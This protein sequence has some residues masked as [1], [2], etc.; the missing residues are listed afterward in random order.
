MIPVRLQYFLEYVWNDWKCDKIWTLGP[1]IYQQNASRNSRRKDG[2]LLEA[3]FSYPRIWNSAK[4]GRFFA[5]NVLFECMLKKTLEVDKMKFR[6]YTNEIVV[7]WNYA[8]LKCC[9]SCLCKCRKF[10]FLD[11]LNIEISK[12]CTGR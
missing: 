12:K 1:R 8:L 2:N 11:I 3:S 5:P 6:S 10:A 9:N 7:F 4:V